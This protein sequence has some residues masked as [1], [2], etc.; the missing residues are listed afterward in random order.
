MALAYAGR[1]AT[2]EFD[3]GL[4]SLTPAGTLEEH[5]SASQMRGNAGRL[6]GSQTR[7]SDSFD[8]M[9]KV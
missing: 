2:A 4:L 9:C 8:R 7:E 6:G 3:S 5:L 1:D